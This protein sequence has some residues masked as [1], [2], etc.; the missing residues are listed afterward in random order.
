MS[1]RTTAMAPKAMAIPFQPN[2]STRFMVLFSAAAQ[3]SRHIEQ[4]DQPQAHVR[5]TREPTGGLFPS[6]GT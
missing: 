4:K 3:G 1:S 2:R 5:R 6:D